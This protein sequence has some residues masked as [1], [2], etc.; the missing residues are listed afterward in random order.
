MTGKVSLVGA[1]PGDPG[2]LTLKGYQIL[3]NSDVVVYDYLANPELL[4]ETKTGA[5]LIYVGMHREERLSQEKVN[6]LLVE[7]ARQGKQVCRLKGGD[8]FVFGRGGEEAEF[9]ASAG[10]PFEI[11][12]GVSAGYAVPAY[13]GIPLTHRRFS[14][15]V[16]F[17]TGHEDP[18]K[19]SIPHLDWEAIAHGA[20]TLVFFM[21]VKGLPEIARNL[22]ESGRPP[23]TPIALIRWGTR[24]EQ[25][26]IS[27][28]LE[29][30]AEQ[31]ET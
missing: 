6:R 5:E 18:E 15:S 16:L 27:G 13:A 2:L 21:G 22:I 1:G 4:L 23:A 17:I 11:V 8:P 3:R 7:R 10:V 24:G 25:E 29:S 19:A 30:I 12:P 31:V 28:T 9:I 20:S 26:V 14:S